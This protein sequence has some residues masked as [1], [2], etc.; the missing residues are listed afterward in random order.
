MCVH[1]C[2]LQV[3]DK[4]FKINV[5]GINFNPD[6]D[7]SEED[8]SD[9]EKQAESDTEMKVFSLD[10]VNKSHLLLTCKSIASDNCD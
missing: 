10:F 6:D 7:S 8:E 9:D 4:K 5:L 1:A 2:V 3:H